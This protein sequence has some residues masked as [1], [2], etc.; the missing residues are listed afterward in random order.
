MK[1]F[2]VVRSS[3]PKRRSAPFSIS[4]NGE[5]YL[6]DIET[7]EEAE[8]IAAM[9]REIRE[10]NSKVIAINKPNHCRAGRASESARWT[11]LLDR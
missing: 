6:S 9:L 1:Q 3:D 5:S 10:A 11:S 8:S 4:L 2:T 7:Q